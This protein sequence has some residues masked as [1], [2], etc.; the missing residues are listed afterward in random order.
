MTSRSR[1]MS[2]AAAMSIERTTS[3]NNNVTCLYSALSTEAAIEAPHASQNRA[4][5]RGAAPHDRH[6]AG[7]LVS[8]IRQG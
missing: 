8:V 6:T 1:S 7:A 3:A 2:S 4:P 5:A